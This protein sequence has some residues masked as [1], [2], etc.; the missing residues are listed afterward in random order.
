MTAL[1]R[2]LDR[3]EQISGVGFTAIIVR[4]GLPG[5]REND[6]AASGEM[7]WARQDGES[8]SEFRTR[9]KTAARAVGAKTII[10]G[11]FPNG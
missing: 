3:L 6:F 2:R 11:G 8:A 7:N 4:G 5:D 1:S 10:F 9:A